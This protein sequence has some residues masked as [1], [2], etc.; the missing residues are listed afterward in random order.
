[1]HVGLLLSANAHNELVKVV[2]NASGICL[3]ATYPQTGMQSPIKERESVGFW[4]ISPG[5]IYTIKQH[6][7]SVFSHTH[8][9]RSID[10]AMCLLYRALVLDMHYLASESEMA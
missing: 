7:Y 6:F 5:A 10:C 1:M 8:Q 9:R 4:L 2:K 3:A